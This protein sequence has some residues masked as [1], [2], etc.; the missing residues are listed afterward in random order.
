MCG[1]TE[2]V[3]HIFFPGEVGHGVGHGACQTVCLQHPQATIPA[4]T[5][6][7]CAWPT[8]AFENFTGALFFVVET[9]Q[10]HTKRTPAGF[11]KNGPMN[12]RHTAYVKRYARPST[13]GGKKFTS[14]A[15]RKEECSLGGGPEPVLPK[16]KRN[17]TQGWCGHVGCGLAAAHLGCTGMSEITRQVWSSALMG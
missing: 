3:A 16:I 11:V 5:L 14:H 10:I 9:S 2:N 13:H 7:C 6:V 17:L 8:Q 1:L 15:G 4:Q 12:K